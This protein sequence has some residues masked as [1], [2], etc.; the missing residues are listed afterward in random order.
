[1]N[2]IDWIEGEKAEVE[3]KYCERCGCLWLRPKGV[4]EVHCAGCRV[5]VA[6]MVRVLEERARRPRLPRPKR[7]DIQ[8]QMQIASLQGIAEREVRP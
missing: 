8:S 5:Y 7:E 4:G 3:L 2:F 6:Q 1:M